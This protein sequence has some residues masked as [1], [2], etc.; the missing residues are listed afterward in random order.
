MTL[1]KKVTGAADNVNRLCLKLVTRVQS[2]SSNNRSGLFHLSLKLFIG[3]RAT[4]INNFMF[5]EENH[6]L[7]ERYKNKSGQLCNYSKHLFNFYR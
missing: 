6:Q 7:F 3:L 5:V 1:A 4:A 2:H